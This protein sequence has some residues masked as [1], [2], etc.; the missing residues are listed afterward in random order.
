M[1]DTQLDPDMDPADPVHLEWK[2]KPVCGSDDPFEVTSDINFT[3]CKGCI[4]EHELFCEAERESLL[5]PRILALAKHLDCDPDEIEEGPH[6]AYEYGRQEWL[7][8]TDS[9]AAEKAAE[10]IRETVWGFNASWIA[11]YT[12]NGI[13]EDTVKAIQGDRCEDANAPLTALIE[14]GRG[15]KEFIEDSIGA[16]GRGHFVAQY[17]GDEHESEGYYLYRVN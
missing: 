8:L 12:P 17:D 5:D 7:V 3:T 15:M 9:E 1:T 13:D 2:G 16:D 14:A 4:Q 10:D 6:G 11:D